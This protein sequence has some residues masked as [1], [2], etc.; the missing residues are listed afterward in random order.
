[1]ARLATWRPPVLRTVATTGAGVP[2][3]VATIERFARRRTARGR[4]ASRPR[5]VAAARDPR[6]DVHAARRARVLGRASS[7][8]CS[9]HRGARS[10]RTPRPSVMVASSSD[11]A[12]PGPARSR[13]HRRRDADGR[14]L[15]AAVRLP[16]DAPEDVGQHRVRFVETGDATLELVEPLARTRRWRSFSSSAAPGCI[17]LRARAGHSRGAWR[18]LKARGVR[19]DRR[20]AAAGAHG[21]AHRVPASGERRR[22]ARRA[23]GTW[24]PTRGEPATLRAALG[25][26][27]LVSALR[28]HVP[29]RRRRDVRRRAEAAVGAARAARRA[30]PH[31][32]RTA[33]AARPAPAHNVLIDAGI[34][35]KMSAKERRHLCASIAPSTS[36][37]RWPRAGLTADDIDVVI[38]THLHFD[39]VGGFTD[40]RRRRACRAAFPAR[41]LL[42]APRRVGGRDAPARAQ[43]RQLSAGEL[44]AA[45][46]GAASIDFIE[47]DGEVVPGISVWRTGGHTM[48]HQIVQIESGGPDRPCSSPT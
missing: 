39:H 8:G 35:D 42:R 44:R 3:L 4:A 20:G 11:G 15:F 45:R 37:R 18:A 17:T 10:I 16:T 28:R 38:A 7:I 14:A 40:A 6:A 43:S 23:Q 48:H 19:L 25:D 27:E 30:Q 41:A 13:R 22:R 24:L 9:T 29:P 31:H 34:G 47:D 12:R 26:F 5:R 2:E 1:M 46:R 36:S 33:A 32:A 21:I